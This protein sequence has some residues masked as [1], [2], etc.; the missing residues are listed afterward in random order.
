MAELKDIIAYYCKEYPH[1]A[2][3]SKARLTKM[4]YLADWKSAIDRGKQISKIEWIYNHY[5]PYVDDVANTAQKDP[6]FNIESTTNMFGGNKEVVRL[7]SEK[8]SPSLHDD[9]KKILNHIISITSD[10]YWN[11]F[12]ELVYST[13]PI[14]KSDKYSTLDL[15]ALA[16]EYKATK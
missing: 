7:R 15:V 11:T 2:E 14:L 4:V 3:L 8:Y 16:K 6:I 10:K 1:K 5:G 12:M 13:Y 9:E